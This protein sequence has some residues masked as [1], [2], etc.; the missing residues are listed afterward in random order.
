MRSLSHYLLRYCGVSKFYNND[1]FCNWLLQ[2]DYYICIAHNLKGYDGV[3]IMQY[4]INN[5]LPNDKYMFI[6]EGLKINLIKFNKVKII[7]SLNFIPSSLA[8][9]PKTFGLTE[10]KKGSF[11]HKFNIPHNHNYNQ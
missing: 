10:L 8:K 6:N 7:D 11:P 9:F 5:P 4:L 1:D 2:Q 3:F